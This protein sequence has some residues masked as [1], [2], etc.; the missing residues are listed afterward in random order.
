MEIQNY[1][2]NKNNLCLFEEDE[3][4]GVKEADDGSAISGLWGGEWRWL[5]MTRFQIDGI[6][7]LLD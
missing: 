3:V 6:L 4:V 1:R 5:R 2:R 7:D